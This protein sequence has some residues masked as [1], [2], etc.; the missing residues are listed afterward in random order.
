[1]KQHERDPGSAKHWREF[2]DHLM[3]NVIYPEA[4]DSYHEDP[5]AD[6]HWEWAKQ[7]DVREAVRV[8]IGLQI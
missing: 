2:S 8:S 4:P 7:T 5:K 1:V 6:P 3:W